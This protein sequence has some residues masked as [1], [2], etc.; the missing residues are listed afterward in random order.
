MGLFGDIGVQPQLLVS[1]K[2]KYEGNTDDYKDYVNGFDV[3]V[4]I[5]VGYEYKKRVGLSAR[6]YMGLSNINK[7]DTDSKD[8]NRV[9]SLRLHVRL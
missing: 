5:G 9:F 4:P 2:D 1:A 8:H 7:M 3:G 6:Y